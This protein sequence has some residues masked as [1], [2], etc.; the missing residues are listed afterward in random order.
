MPGSPPADPRFAAARDA[1]DSGDGTGFAALLAADPT[2]VA[3]R[4]GHGND[5]LAI[6]VATGSEDAVAR[7]LAAGADPDAANV[8]GWTA[9]HQAG[10]GGQTALVERLLAAGA[11]PD[12]EARGAGGTPL[13]Q[14]LFWGHR[15]AAER[16]AAA[17]VVPANL[18]VAA[19]LGDLAR[20]ERLV[21]PDGALAPVAG[22]ARE[23]HRPHSGFPAW[24]P[25]DDPAEIRDEALAWA[26]RNGRDGAIEALVAR[27]ARVDADVHRGTAL[28]WAAA[29]GHAA[30]IAML[31][32]L[33]ADPDGRSTFGGPEHGEGVVPLHLAAQYGHGDA[34]A[35]LL[36]AG[37]DPTLRDRLHDTTPRA[38][39]AHGP[40]PAVAEG[41]LP[42]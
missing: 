5:L 3:A 2:L 14:A 18:R 6:A 1:L 27:G 9:L 34:I 32:R 38:W 25:S 33:G 41:L 42:A 40:R 20:L 17:I 35:A 8:H 11:R 37:A 12:R 23:F 26:A 21:G 28:A 4:D 39:A 13:V 16:L 19:G 7:L 24:R 15:E 30:T 36:D 31:V 10:Y 29:N 22:A